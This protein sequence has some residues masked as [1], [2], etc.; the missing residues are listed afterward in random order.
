MAH[1]RSEAEVISGLRTGTAWDFPTTTGRVVQNGE[2][3]LIEFAVVADG[4]WSDLTRTV[5][6]GTMTDEQRRLAAA[7]RAAYLAALAGYET[8]RSRFRA[9]RSCP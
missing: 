9:R 5:V 8:R 4:Y 2:L 3:V 1:A 7:Q 6:A